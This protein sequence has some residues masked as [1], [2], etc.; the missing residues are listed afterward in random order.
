[1]LN[2]KLF[3]LQKKGRN[4]KCIQISSETSLA[5]DSRSNI[6]TYTCL[7]TFKIKN[8]SILFTTLNNQSYCYIND[9][10][11]ESY[12]LTVLLIPSKKNIYIKFDTGGN[13]YDFELNSQEQVQ[14]FAL[15]FESTSYHSTI[16]LDRTLHTYPCTSTAEGIFPM[17]LSY[18]K[19]LSPSASTFISLQKEYLCEGVCEN[20]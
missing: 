19:A 10:P 15:L 6:Q 8:A 2:E 18:I 3:D 13:C 12:N 17:A 20:E 7:C 14:D 9:T 1:M 11:I 16:F 5:R 4:F